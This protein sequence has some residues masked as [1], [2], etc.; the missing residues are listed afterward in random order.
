M[1]FDQDLFEGFQ[2]DDPPILRF[3]YYEKPFLTLGRLEA[4]RLDPSKLPYPYEVRPTGGRA[5][6]H[7]PGD[8]CY[9][10]V[11]STSDPLVGGDLLVSYRKIS[12]LLAGALRSLGR[13]VSL[14][15]EKHKGTGAGHCFSSPSPAELALDGRK[16]AGGAQARRGGVFLQQG[17]ILLS[18]APGW[19]SL[20]QGAPDAS[21]AGLN[22]ATLPPIGRDALERAIVKA[23][24][25][26]G[27]IFK[28]T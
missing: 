28:K 12:E 15:T 18:V 24:E 20:F 3:F 25:S 27:V 10:I 4:R 1:A 23:F 14:S 19:K 17:T 21:M 5:V 9:S 22:D 7:G 11:S 13:E 2:P 26:A 6:L 8:L 16:V